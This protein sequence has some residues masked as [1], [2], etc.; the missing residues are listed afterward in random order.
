MNLEIATTL[1]EL[2]E[3]SIAERDAKLARQETERAAQEA[4]AE[5][6]F[7]SI[8]A[9]A[10]DQSKGDVPAPL[11]PF[12]AHKGNRPA[13]DMLERGTWRP[14]ELVIDAPGLESIR[15]VIGESREGSLSVHSLRIGADHETYGRDEW[16]DVIAIA[17]VRAQE[18]RAAVAELT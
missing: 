9:S 12:V 8:V 15:L 14:S 13:L 2:I 16:T 10:I 7:N 5:A 1:E 4:R 18:A 11:R 17:A 6:L 3:R